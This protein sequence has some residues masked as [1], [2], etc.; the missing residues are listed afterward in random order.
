M[1]GSAAIKEKV[2]SIIAGAN[3]YP[4]LFIGSGLSMRYM[5]TRT[6]DELLEWLCSTVLGNEFAF[7]RAK[8]E[9][10]NA[11]RNKMID[12]LM[13]YVA[14]LIED[15]VNRTLLSDVR[16]DW[17]RKRYMREL[18]EGVSPIKQFIADDLSKAVIDECNEVEIL[19][20]RCATKSRV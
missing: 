3:C 18:K 7:A 4:F 14:T 15:D 19:T 5:H 16:F 1:E 12:S 11:L 20:K 10:T 17:F 2:A 8:A 6:W 9:A 13:P